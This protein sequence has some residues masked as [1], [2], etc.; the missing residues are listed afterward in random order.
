MLVLWS[1]VRLPLID[2]CKMCGVEEKLV[3][4]HILPRSIVP[5]DERANLCSINRADKKVTPR[6]GLMFNKYILCDSCETKSSDFDKYYIETFRGDLSKIITIVPYDN[7]HFLNFRGVDKN[8]IRRFI[9]WSILRQVFVDNRVYGNQKKR[10]GCYISK[11]HVENLKCIVNKDKLSPDEVEL[12]P[13]M[14][15]FNKKSLD[16]DFKNILQNKETGNKV[17]IFPANLKDGMGSLC[18]FRIGYFVFKQYLFYNKGKIHRDFNWSSNASE[19]VIVP[20]VDEGVLP[21][22]EEL[23]SYATPRGYRKG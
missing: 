5:S 10:D 16:P 17:I 19:S 7:T 9:Q 21:G 12:Y 6:Q 8:K 23:K 11:K 1:L 3:R 4:S 13:T 18:E 15:T 14:I 22:F 20:L 2:V